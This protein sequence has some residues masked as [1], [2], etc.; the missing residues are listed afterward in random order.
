MTATVPPAERL[1]PGWTGHALV[2]VMVTGYLILALEPF[3]WKPPRRVVNG[4]EWTSE[5]TLRIASEGKVAGGSSPPWAAAAIRL[6]AFQIKLRVRAF[7]SEGPIFSYSDWSGCPRN[8]MIGQIGPDLIVALRTLNSELSGAPGLFAP[9]VFAT[10]EWRDVD[11]TVRSGAAELFVDGRKVM[12]AVLPDRSLSAWQMSKTFNVTLAN[13]IDGNHPWLGE[14]AECTVRA[15][16]RTVDYLTGGAEIP[17]AYRVNFKYHLK[18]SLQD[19]G[20][21]A[22]NFLCF[23]PLGFVL[24]TLFERHRA[25]RS[26][27][28]VCAGMSF[29]VEIAQFVFDHVPSTTDWISNSLGAAL[30]AVAARH[31]L[32]TRAHLV[33]AG[34]AVGLRVPNAGA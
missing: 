21:L 1:F 25:V 23:I 30:G 2:V 12:S 11:L 18:P 4:A 3:H 7:A 31:R 16:D 14:I 19:P 27:V 34:R 33:A 29:G 26:T 8:V 22:L 24:C 10:S 17:A 9:G 20:D 15:G 28:L 5:G 32:V 13:E 6:D